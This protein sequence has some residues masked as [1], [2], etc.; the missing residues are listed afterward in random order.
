[1]GSFQTSA[2]SGA[3]DRPFLADVPQNNGGTTKPPCDSLQNSPEVSLFICISLLMG[4]LEINCRCLWT[5]GGLQARA[6]LGSHCFAVTEFLVV[7]STVRLRNAEKTLGAFQIWKWKR[8]VVHWIFALQIWSFLEKFH[9]SIRLLN[10]LMVPT[11]TEVS[12]IFH[13]CI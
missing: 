8:F 4:K 12:C 7:I 13:V 1:M 2:N 6:A 9:L 11:G 5:V 3:Y 10:K